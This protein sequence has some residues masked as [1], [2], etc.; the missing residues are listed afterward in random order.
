[1]NLLIFKFTLLKD[2]NFPSFCQ[3]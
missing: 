1:M 2:Q 3:P